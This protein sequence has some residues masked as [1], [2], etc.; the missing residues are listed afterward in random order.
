MKTWKK[1]ADDELAEV[2]SRTN[3]MIVDGLNLAFR[4]RNSSKPF[5]SD[6]VN[7]IF[8]LA[9]T[10]KAKQIIIV[11]DKGKSKYRKDLYPEYKANRD[12]KF[13]AMTEEE[14]EQSKQ[15]FEYYNEALDLCMTKLPTFFKKGVEGDDLAAFAVVMLEDKFEHVWMIS[16][17]GDWDGLLTENVSRFS[18]TTRK[19]YHLH[20]FYD[21]HGCDSP[22]QFVSLKAM[23]GDLGDNIRGVEGIGAKRGYGILREYGSV[24]DIVDTLPLPGKQTFIKNLNE[25]EDVLLRNLQLVDLRSFCAEAIMAVGDDYFAEYSAALENLVK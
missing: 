15:F 2:A 11:S 3:L 5:A 6:F 19:E 17:D 24:L 8:S 1:M 20:T 14:I 23:M 13:E 9:K 4:Y 25:S 22:E 21:A 16:T 7:T 12:A 10:Y 18:Y